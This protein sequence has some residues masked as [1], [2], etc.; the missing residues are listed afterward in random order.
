M[1]AYMTS[2]RIVVSVYIIIISI[3]SFF[4]VCAWGD[5]DI[6]FPDFFFFCGG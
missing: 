3:A 1:Y 2:L 5:F 4:V 6:S